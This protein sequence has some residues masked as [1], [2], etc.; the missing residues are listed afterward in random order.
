MNS[1]LAQLKS[2]LARRQDQTAPLRL[3]FRDDD[4]DEDEATLRRLLQFFLRRET[5]INLGV[6]PGRLTAA[7]GELLAQSVSDAPALLELNQHG[8]RHLNHELVGRKLEFGPGRTFA[9]QMSDIAQGQARMTEAFGPHWFPVFIPPWNR[10]VEDTYRAL[11]QL[12]FRALSAKQGNSVVT[13]YR[14]REIS[15]TLDLYRWQG[16]ARMKP[17]EEIVGDLIAQLSR[18]QTIGVMLHHKV[19]DESA[20]S[21]LGFLLDALAAHSIVHFHTFQSLVQLSDETPQV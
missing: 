2:A 12:G 17:S 7:G 3:F 21:F 10:C 19:M 9:E 16:G 20:F 6:I 18:Q 1:S 4:V 13:G 15:I 11:D 14:F 8:W 5:P